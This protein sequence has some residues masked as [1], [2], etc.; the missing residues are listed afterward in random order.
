MLPQKKKPYQGFLCQAPFS[1][2]A[3]LSPMDLIGEFSGAEA[4]VSATRNPPISHHLA[5]TVFLHTDDAGAI[6]KLFDLQ[7]D[8]HVLGP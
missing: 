5:S 4:S 7:R 8:H 1:I 3:T 6:L 2:D